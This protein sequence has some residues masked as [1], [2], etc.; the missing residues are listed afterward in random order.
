MQT[1]SI[2]ASTPRAANWNNRISLIVGALLVLFLSFDIVIKLVQ[3]P[4]AVESTTEF[5]YA[6]SV[7]ASL[8]LI[9]LACLLLYLIPATSVVGAILL[10]GYLGGA[11]ATHVQAG[12]DPFSLVFPVILG[13]LLWGVLFLR[14]GRLR[15]LVPLR[16]SNS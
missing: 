13:A 16:Q 10:T 14:D 7:V 9:Q 5:G 6:A 11:V 12:S 3:H 15:A 4:V 1:I 8:G 2:P